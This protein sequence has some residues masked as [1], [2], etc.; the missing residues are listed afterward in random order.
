MSNLV[1]S[2]RNLVKVT[3]VAMEGI[4]MPM[5]R[6]IELCRRPCLGR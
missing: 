2:R 3:P 1:G 6:M 4:M 5:Q